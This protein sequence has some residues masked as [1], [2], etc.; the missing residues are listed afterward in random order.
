MKIRLLRT[1]GSRQ[2]RGE[3]H[4]KKIDY[5]VPEGLRAFLVMSDAPF[6]VIA[7]PLPSEPQGLNHLLASI[8]I[9]ITHV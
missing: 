8:W 4:I 6:I 2:M 3:G 9:K 7:V 5:A 1:V